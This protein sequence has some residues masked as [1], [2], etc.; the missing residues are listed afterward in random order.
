MSPKFV[1]LELLLNTYRSDS[2]VRQGRHSRYIN[3][4]FIY[5]CLSHSEEQNPADCCACSDKATE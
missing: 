4:T 5:T 1:A 3:I 2:Q